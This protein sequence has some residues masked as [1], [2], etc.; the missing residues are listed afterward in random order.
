MSSEERTLPTWLEN[1]PVLNEIWLDS[2]LIPHF[3][4][5]CYAFS[6]PVKI[7]KALGLRGDEYNHFLSDFNNLESHIRSIYDFVKL[8]LAGQLNINAINRA[9]ESSTGLAM[10]NKIEQEKK[11]NELKAELMPSLETKDDIFLRGK[12]NDELSYYSQLQEFIFNGKPMDAIPAT[13]QAYWSKLN[14]VHDII[15]SFEFRAKGRKYATSIICKKFGCSEQYAYR[16]VHEAT[17]FF[18]INEDKSQWYKRLLDDLEKIK[19]L[20]WQSND[21]KVFVEAVKEQRNLLDQM[22]DNDDIPPEVFEARTIITSHD[23]TLFNIKPVSRKELK[24]RVMK[25][26]LSKEEKKMILKDIDYSDESDT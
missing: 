12:I 22:K 18:C 10:F 24:A 6:S 2:S 19:A 7:A 3:V 20:A 15:S 16:I 4:N 25:Y 9:K 21:F 17:Q 13:L 5:H 14:I 26:K 23:P 1:S 8:E 11:I